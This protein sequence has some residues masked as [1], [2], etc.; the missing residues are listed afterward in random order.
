MLSSDGPPSLFSFACTLSG[1]VDLTS[2]CRL[3]YFPTEDF[4]QATFAIVNTG[5]Y[6][7]FMEEAVL[8]D[9]E[10]K[11]DEY[12]SYA[13]LAQVNLETCL[14]N[15]PLFLSAKVETIQAL[16]LGVSIRIPAVVCLST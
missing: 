14:A 13:S 12:R 8:C 6:N 7:L 15:L 1:I 9:D 2:L 10:I 5:L 16:L 3:V 11:H 4:S